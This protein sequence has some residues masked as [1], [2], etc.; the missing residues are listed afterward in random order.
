MRVGLLMRLISLIY[1]IKA[2][3]LVA[4]GVEPR[5]F[6]IFLYYAKCRYSMS[7]SLFYFIHDHVW[8]KEGGGTLNT[9]TTILALIWHFIIGLYFL[10]VTNFV[11]CGGMLF[12]RWDCPRIKVFLTFLQALKAYFC[13][14]PIAIL[15]IMNITYHFLVLFSYFVRLGHQKSVIFDWPGN[16][17]NAT[18][19]H[20]ETGARQL[21]CCIWEF[22]TKTQLTWEWFIIQWITGICSSYRLG[23]W[24]HWCTLPLVT[25]LSRSRELV[26]PQNI[27]KIGRGFSFVG[28][29]S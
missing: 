15:F 7:R 5:I 2:I 23:I 1:K 6:L 11:V 13:I 20:V 14:M 24:F 18:T 19:S 12:Q 10:R 25:Y 28:S 21:L 4:A 3:Y 17:R 16:Q 29:G 22:S 26:T 8:N 27:E 9:V